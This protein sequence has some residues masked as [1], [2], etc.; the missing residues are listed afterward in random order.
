MQSERTCSTHV[1]RSS[2]SRV[3][4]IARRCG[5]RDDEEDDIFCRTIAEAVFKVRRHMNALS[6]SEVYRVAGEFECRSAREHIEE[7]ACARVKVPD[8]SGTR[9]HTLLNDAEIR[10][11]QKMPTVA[12]GSPGVVLGA[13]P[14]NWHGVVWHVCILIERFFRNV[15]RAA[16]SELFE[17]VAPARPSIPSIQRSFP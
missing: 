7:L 8:L 5:R 13:R 12:D 15:R 9:R 17:V 10:A 14:I 4:A 16:A 3:C 1:I 2:L 11:L 6:G